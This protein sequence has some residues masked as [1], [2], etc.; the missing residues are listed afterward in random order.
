MGVIHQFYPDERRH[1]AQNLETAEMV[2]LL[3]AII[4][5]DQA[6][7]AEGERSEQDNVCEKIHDGPEALC[8]AE[9]VSPTLKRR[10]ARMADARWLGEASE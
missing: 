2:L 10:A 5:H 6:D 4:V 1:A 8:L 3:L 9:I 7:N